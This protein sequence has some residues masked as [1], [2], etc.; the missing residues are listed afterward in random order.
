MPETYVTRTGR[1]LTEADVERLADRA[2]AGFDL[3]TWAPRPGRPALGPRSG[4]EKASPRIDV[5]IPEALHRRVTAMASARGQS[6]SQLI[7][8]L[9]EEFVRAG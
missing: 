1:R 9:L 7:R 3:S 6:V 4:S 8:T 5:R 2:E